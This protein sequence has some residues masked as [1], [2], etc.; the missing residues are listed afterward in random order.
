MLG[1]DSWLDYFCFFFFWLSQ[2][3]Q[4]NNSELGCLYDSSVFFRM[5]LG[6]QSHINHSMTHNRSLGDRPLL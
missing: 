6:Q 5:V 4:D 3:Q 1:L 2:G